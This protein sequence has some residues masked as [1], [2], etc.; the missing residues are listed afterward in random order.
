MCRVDR[1]DDKLEGNPTFLDQKIIPYL[2]SP[3]DIDRNKKR[4][5]ASCWIKSQCESKLMWK[6]FASYGVA[7]RTTADNLIK[8][9]DKDCIYQEHLWEIR[10]VDESVRTFNPLER[11]NTYK[12]LITKMKEFEDEKEVRL[13]SQFIT[14]D[15]KQLDYIAPDVDLKIL[16]QEIVVAPGLNDAFVDFINIL[17]L[18]YLGFKIPIRKSVLT[19]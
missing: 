7:I 14:E 9:L 19:N 4:S 11:I 13:I 16:L 17:I 2:C 3:I 8:S 15:G 6:T 18:S 1:F 12:F 5:F 10:Y